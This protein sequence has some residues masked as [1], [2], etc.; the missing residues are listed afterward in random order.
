M[1]RRGNLRIALL[2]SFLVVPRQDVAWA[3]PPF[4]VE[5]ADPNPIANYPGLALDAMG[6]PHVSYQSPQEPVFGGDTLKYATRSGGAWIIE[7]VSAPGWPFVGYYSNLVVG[8]DGS[9]HIACSDYS[10]LT[11]EYS[12]RYARRVG[13]AWT[14]ETPL[15]GSELGFQ[16]SIALDAV[17]NAVVSYYREDPGDLYLAKKSNGLWSTEPVDASGDVGEWNS[18]ALDSQ[19]NPHV[20]Y[21]DFTNGNLKYASKAGGLWTI[22]TVDAS[23]NNVGKY[24]SLAIDA[25]GNPHIT[26]HDATADDVKYARKRSG[27]WQIE[28]ADGAT[29]AVGRRGTSLAL[30]AR[31]FAHVTYFDDT[32]YA[33]R[34]TRKSAGAWTTQVIDASS[35]F[36][37]SLDLDAAGYPRICF[38]RGGVKYATAGWLALP[39]GVVTLAGAAKLDAFSHSGPQDPGAPSLLAY[40][41][42]SRGSLRIYC[43]LTDGAL[44]QLAMYDAEGRRV[45]TF[46]HMHGAS[47]I[48]TWDGTDDSGHQVGVGA[49]FLRLSSDAGI[50]AIRQV[51]ILK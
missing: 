2:I 29:N 19:G 25:Q 41:N 50:Q 7:T 30:D 14:I 15:W 26:Y 49:Y 28:T 10:D 39:E 23:A 31:G 46:P 38:T 1:Q 27:I 22:E 51:T 33:L 4:I 17:D 42:P 6:N 34:Y 48:E 47:G 20:S 8:T 16:T 44:A 37:S 12:F 3:T 35:G 11:F 13:G 24:T 18:L 9:P 43:R 5:T 36:R 32:A 40:P 21:Y 45:R